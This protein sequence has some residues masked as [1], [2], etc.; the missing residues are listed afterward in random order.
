MKVQRSSSW[1]H[2][3]PVKVRSGDHLDVPDTGW[4]CDELCVPRRMHPSAVLRKLASSQPLMGNSSSAE[5]TVGTPGPNPRGVMVCTAPHPGC[6]LLRRAMSRRAES[7]LAAIK[8]VA[9][10]GSSSALPFFIAVSY[11]ERHVL[12]D[13]SAGRITSYR[14]AGFG[15]PGWSE[16][17]NSK[18]VCKVCK[19]P[20]RFWCGQF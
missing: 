12:L 19:L 15:Q 4:H 5:S 7:R 2:A 3:G 9:P 17:F 1:S 18:Q 10:L 11:L 6:G 14:V 16:V 13:N 20:Q 8:T